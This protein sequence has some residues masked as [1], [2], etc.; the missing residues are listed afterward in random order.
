MKMDSGNL[1]NWPKWKLFSEIIYWLLTSFKICHFSHM[2][3]SVFEQDFS[4]IYY[5]H[6][7]NG[8]EKGNKPAQL[9]AISKTSD[10][11]HHERLFNKMYSNIWDVKCFYRFKAKSHQT[12]QEDK[13]L[14]FSLVKTQ[15][16]LLLKPLSDFP[17]EFIKT[18]W[19]CPSPK[20]N[21]S[22]KKA[23]ISKVGHSVR[24]LGCPKQERAKTEL[25]LSSLD[26]SII[27]L[28]QHW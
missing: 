22:N 16:Q 25:I 14:P 24:A 26:N 18:P 28:I 4:W 9:F 15:Q 13:W 6:Q 1:Q 19:L 12:N 2:G 20:N 11:V 21:K 7:N 10:R 8:R 3:F 5:C 17:P 23:A 27:S